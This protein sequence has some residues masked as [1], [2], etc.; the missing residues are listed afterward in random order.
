MQCIKTLFGCSFSILSVLPAYINMCCTRRIFSAI[1]NTITLLATQQLLAPRSSINSF[2]V[3]EL[4]LFQ[5]FRFV[6]FVTYNACSHT[7]M[8]VLHTQYAHPKR[9]YPSWYPGPG[10]RIRGQRGC[11]NGVQYPH[12][13]IFGKITRTPHRRIFQKF[14][15][16]LSSRLGD[17]LQKNFGENSE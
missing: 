8:Y 13:Q 11:Q 3:F 10:Y 2:D 16:T 12:S 7:L 9:G 14:G 4:D 1:V 17:C 5:C 6:A 15:G